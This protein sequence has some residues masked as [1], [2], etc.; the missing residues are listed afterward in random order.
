[1]STSDAPNP[2][3]PV[4]AKKSDSVLRTFDLFYYHIVIAWMHSEMRACMHACAHMHVQLILYQSSKVKAS[5]A[6]GCV[7]VKYADETSWTSKNPP[8]FAQEVFC[9]GRM[10][11]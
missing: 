8:R 9:T 6:Y 10:I 7:A 1:M 5:I 11:T 3:A 2:A 4:T